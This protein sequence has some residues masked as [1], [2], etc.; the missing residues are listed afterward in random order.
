M[1][2]VDWKNRFALLVIIVSLLRLV[3]ATA[4]PI[5]L[6]QSLDSALAHNKTLQITR[7]QKLLTQ[8]R[9]Q[10]AVANFI[11]KVSV[12]ADYKYFTD[13]PT[14]LMPLSTFNPS[15]PEGQ[16][17]VAQFGVPHNLNAHIQLSAP[18]YNPQL[19]GA[20]RSTRIATELSELQYQKTEDQVLVEVHQLYYSAQLLTHQMHLVDS[21][22]ANTNRLL[23]NMR[24]LKEHLLGK[25]TDVGKVELQA[26]Q[27]QTQKASL[28]NKS[29]QVRN[30]LKIAMGMPLDKKITVEEKIYFEEATPI[31]NNQSLEIKIA[32]TQQK[33]AR[34]ELQNMRMLRLPSLSL[35]ASYGKAGFGYDKEPNSFLNF[36]PIGFAGVQLS[37]P[38]FNGTVTQRKINQ[39]KLELNNSL[40]QEALVRDQ[41][42]MHAINLIGQL[43]VARKTIDQAALQQSQANN[44][45]AQTVA[46]HKQGVASL[47]EVLL[48]DAALREAQ[49]QY[50][51]ALV[52]YLKADLEL[53]KITGNISN[54]Q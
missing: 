44:I 21:N 5:S 39:K 22:I 4:Q 2:S 14:Q 27:L 19:H 46:Q 6:S 50:L 1:S 26:A 53:K 9:R 54:A 10:E 18:L 3:P 25:G 12:N 49:Q 7:N 15:A 23:K 41:N 42:D 29:E 30:A 8:E 43:Q 47:T 45:Y 24:L 32:Q 51:N 20:L 28:E 17:K 37:Y 36:Y 34:T 40:L 16:F 11:P 35:I 48:A 33:L 31:S 13:L 52:D 38:L